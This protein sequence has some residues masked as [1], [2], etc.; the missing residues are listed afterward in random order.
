MIDAISTN[1]I[2][3]MLAKQD[4]TTGVIFDVKRYAIHDGPGIRTTVFLKGCPL[5]CRWCHNP[6]S[7]QTTPE[8][9]LRTSRCTA[10][11]RCVEAC[12]HGAITDTSKCNLCGACVEACPS[13]AREMVGRS[14]TVAQLMTQ[15]EQDVPFFDQSKGGAT[16]SGGEPLGQPDFLEELLAECRVREIHTAVDTT[17]YAPWQIVEKTA[18]LADLFLVDIKHMDPT[19]H[20]QYTGVSNELILDN[21][22]RLA[23]MDTEM[24]VRV[25]LI[26]GINDDESNLTATGEFIASLKTVRR[27]D[28]LP[29]HEA[30]RAKMGRLAAVRSLLQ[31]DPTEPRRLDEAKEQLETFDLSVQI[32]G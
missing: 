32:G 8:L 18:R 10:C 9:S 15:I 4:S 29:H 13:G 14:M 20:Q 22:R 26:S 16:F 25:P 2:R 28:L 7:W 21:T 30:A 3:Q 17:C 5:Q 19:A 12:P 27:V 1:P 24:I 11:E 31:V 23:A 6:E